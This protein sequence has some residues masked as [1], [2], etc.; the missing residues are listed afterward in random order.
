[1]KKICFVIASVFFIV[2]CHGQVPPT[3]HT[4]TLTWQAPATG[5]TTSAPCTYVLSRATVS[6]TTCPGTSGTTYTPLNQS[7]PVSALTYTDSTASGLTV[8]YI[9]QTMQGGAVSIPSNSAL[10]TVPS[11]PLAPAL[12]TPTTAS[13]DPPTSP[14]S[15][16]E[17][18]ASI[19]SPGK[20]SAKAWN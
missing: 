9:A 3:N 6:G 13:S 1:M 2:G 16:P 14:L 7:N 19:E 15:Y 12:G 17:I 4:V 8:C 11:N 5:C 18:L 10:V 20:L